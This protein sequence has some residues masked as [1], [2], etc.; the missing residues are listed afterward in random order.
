MNSAME[1]M[2]KRARTDTAFRQKLLDTHSQKDPL[3]AFC[4]CAQGEGYGITIGDI[5][6]D[7]E[8]YSCNQLKSTNG[9]GVTPYAYFDDP[10]E[11]FFVELEYY[12]KNQPPEKKE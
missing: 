4:R 7:G 11:M 2:A 6:S 8:E 9:G 12:Q 3:A 1:E 10:Y 5:V